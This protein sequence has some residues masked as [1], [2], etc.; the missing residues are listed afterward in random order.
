MKI[1][2]FLLLAALLAAFMAGPALANTDREWRFRVLIDDAEVGTHTFRVAGDAPERRV[3]SDARFNVKFW[4]INAYSYSHQARERWQGEC[5][6]DIDARTDDNGTRTVVRGMRNGAHFDTEGTNG[7]TRLPA[8]V[9]SFAYWN[10]AM[11][12]QTRLLNVQTGELTDV[13]I[14]PLGEEFLQVRGAPTTARRYALHAPKFRI[15]VWY[16]ADAQW[17]KLESRTESG[18]MLRYFIQ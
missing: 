9:M 14:E 5:L 8:C 7:K 1:P 15:D 10:P 17:V 11:L 13:R 3:E 2:L 18:R 6:Q 12:K 4:F 16:T